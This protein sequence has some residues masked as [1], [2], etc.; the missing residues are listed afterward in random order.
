MFCIEPIDKIARRRLIMNKFSP[1]LLTNKLELHIVIQAWRYK[2]AE[3]NNLKKTRQSE[4]EF[5]ITKNYSNPLISAIHI[6]VLTEDYDYFKDMFPLAVLSIV[7]T[8]PTYKTLID[9]ANSLSPCMV[10]ICNTDIEVREIHDKLLNLIDSK[11]L[12]SI[13]RHEI[14][15]GTIIEPRNETYQGSHD[16]FIFQVPSS[17]QTDALNFEQNLYGAENVLMYMF[18]KAGYKIKNPCFEIKIYHHHADNVYFDSYFRINN[19][20]NTHVSP[21]TRLLS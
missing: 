5:A 2:D 6:L 11:T 18:K 21:P 4:I 3:S 17:V 9:Y 7:Q 20:S 1:P 10:C 16:A 12:F 19:S 14:R 8:Q 15:D 13:S